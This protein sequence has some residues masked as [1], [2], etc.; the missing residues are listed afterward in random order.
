MDKNAIELVRDYWRLMVEFWP[1][2][3]EARAN[4][5]H[6]VERMA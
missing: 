1:E 6:L 4:R 3:F 5:R 2:P